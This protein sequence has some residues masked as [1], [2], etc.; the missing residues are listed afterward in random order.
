MRPESNNLMMLT[1]C[2][3]EHSTEMAGLVRLIRGRVLTGRG[4][5]GDE[6]QGVEGF[7]SL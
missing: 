2:C 4:G 5:V 7:R 1:F 3:Q 6:Q